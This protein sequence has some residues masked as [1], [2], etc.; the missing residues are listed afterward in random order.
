MLLIACKVSITY[1][2]PQ[3][4]EIIRDMPTLLRHCITELFSVG[5]LV[6]MFRM[7]VIICFLC[8]LLYF[9]SPLDIIPEAA[10]GLLGFIDDFF[11][12]L[13]LA[14]YVSIIYRRVVAN[15]GE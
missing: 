14:I 13:L 7:R 12:L 5:G 15:Q 1:F 11:I 2:F 6:W 4:V 8:A 9:I 10:F 3:L